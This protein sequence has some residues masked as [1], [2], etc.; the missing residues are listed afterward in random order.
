MELRVEGR[1][2]HVYTGGRPDDPARPA[3][4][5]LHGSAQDHTVWLWQSRYLAHHGWRVLA[6][7]LPGH[8]RSEGPPLPRIEDLAG[9]TAALLEAAGAGRAVL[10][11]HSMGSLVALETAATEPD[12]A[13][14]LVLVGTTF[15]MAVNEALLA[16]ARA[17][18][19]AALDMVN[20]WGH[21][22]AMHL[23]GHPVPGMWML[24]AGIRLLERAAPGVL[25]TD[26][27]ACNAY[28]AGLERARRVRCPVLAILGG[29]DRMTPPRAARPLLDAL[30][31]V[32]EVVVPGAGHMLMV[33]APDAVLDALRGFLAEAA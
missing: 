14:A 12:R 22:S 3:V 33:E 19:H 32:R 10:A 1:R 16:A 9:W 20:L 2:V 11:G 24:G 25:Y 18:D 23:G 7:D 30:P 8:G 29:A 27:A 28:A 21:G 15:P 26:L 31:G 17:D 4:V 13:A 5:L 6:V